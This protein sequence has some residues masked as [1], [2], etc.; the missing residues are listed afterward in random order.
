MKTLLEEVQLFCRETDIEIGEYWSNDYDELPLQIE[1]FIKH[2]K[3]VKYQKIKAQ[4][5]ILKDVDDGYIDNVAVR[6]YSLQKQLKQLED[7]SKT[8]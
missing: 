3:W 1:K 8:D 2:S 4:V 5:D 7:E 6:I